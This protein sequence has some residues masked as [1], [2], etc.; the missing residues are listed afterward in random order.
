MTVILINMSGHL[1][2]AKIQRAEDQRLTPMQNQANDRFNDRRVPFRAV[3]DGGRG[4]FF[5]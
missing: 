3:I 1:C 4:A 2:G 5:S